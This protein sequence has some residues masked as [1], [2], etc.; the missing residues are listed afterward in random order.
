MGDA[1]RF[2][3]CL[4]GGTFDRFHAGHRLLLDAAQRAGQAVEIHITSDLMAEHKS[5]DMQSFETRREAV[6]D[7]VERHAPRRVTVHELTDVHG[8]APTHTTADC[9]VATPETRGQCERINEQR[10][11][12]GL[13]PLHIIEVA[14]LSDHTGHILSS[15]RIRN[16]QTDTE[17]HPWVHPSWKDA[18]LHLH[19]RAEPELKSPMGTLYEGPEDQPDVAMYAAL[20]D[21]D[22]DSVMLIAVG[23]V[24]VATLLDMG[25]IPDMAFIDGQT[26]RTPL[27]EE[28]QVNI[29]SFA[30]RLHAVNPAGQLTPSMYDTIVEAASFDQPVVVEVV[31]EEDLAPLYIHLLVPLHAVVVYGQPHRGVVVQP[32]SLATKERCR[33]LLEMFEVD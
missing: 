12:H 3:R 4:V 23:D 24:T 21:L 29:S 7:W 19:A 18:T 32:S 30:H 16:G 22:L 31:G 17:G 1:H 27:A 5:I 15:S 25:Y 2:R 14:H 26:K 13:P 28:N 11:Q 10:E 8:P 9:I 33:R 6:L 20:D